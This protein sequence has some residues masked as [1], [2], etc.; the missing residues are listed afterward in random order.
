MLWGGGDR[1]VG[2][3]HAGITMMDPVAYVVTPQRWTLVVIDEK[4]GRLLPKQHHS[5]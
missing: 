2:E 3:P 1:V 5:C 4:S